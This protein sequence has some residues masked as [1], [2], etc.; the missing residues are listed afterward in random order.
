MESIK[1]RPGQRERSWSPKALCLTCIGMMC[2]EHSG[3]L[4]A[5][6]LCPIKKIKICPM[7]QGC[8]DYE[9]PLR[10][11]PTFRSLLLGEYMPALSRS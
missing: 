4:V 5:G 8:F 9:W 3:P 7:T 1:V 2:Q 10:V 6:E 11:P